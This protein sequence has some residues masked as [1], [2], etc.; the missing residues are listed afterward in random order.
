MSKPGRN[1]LCPCG[2]GLKYKKCHEPIEK[3][4]ERERAAV[5]QA[6][7]YLRQDF[8][9]FARDDRFAPA[10]AA[11]IAHYW[12]GHYSFDNAEE[13]SENE[14]FR[15]VDWFIFD[16]Q[17]E[18]TPRLIEAY[19]Q[20]R[21][22][23]LATSQQKV[24]AGWLDAPP[25]AAYEFTGYEGQTLHLRDFVSGESY[26]VYEASGHGVLEPGDLVLA[27]LVLVN[28]RLQFSTTA[29]YLPQAEIANL[30]DKL[31]AARTADAEAHPGATYPDFMRRH[32]TLLIH[33]A[34]EQAEEKG[35]PAV[36]RLDPDRKDNAGRAAARQLRRLQMKR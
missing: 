11:A 33:H 31:A 29:A 20:E 6:A 30:A 3:E 27:R 17:P 16:Y 10:F 32:N 28:D 26:D 5:V 8:L 15:F 35:R 4:A 9:K 1:D 22:D 2:S 21:W 12:N 18:D 36:A 13:M 34:L 14:A 19:H 23:D 25:A 7:R 24:L